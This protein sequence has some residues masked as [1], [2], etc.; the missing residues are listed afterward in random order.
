MGLTAAFQ[1]LDLSGPKAPPA[2][3]GKAILAEAEALRAASG[4]LGTATAAL[5]GLAAAM[6]AAGEAAG[7]SGSPS[8]ILGLKIAH[9]LAAVERMLA[10][11]PPPVVEQLRIE[12]ARLAASPPETFIEAL[13]LRDLL[14]PLVDATA[15]DHDAAA[16]VDVPWA[17][18]N[19]SLGTMT[20]DERTRIAALRTRLEQAS[21]SPA[22]RRVA[23]IWSVQYADVLGMASNPPA[24]L[25]GPA[26]S[27]WA[28]ST[29]AVFLSLADHPNSAKAGDELARL[30]SIA[31]VARA[32]ESPASPGEAGIAP[33]SGAARAQQALNKAITALP[34]VADHARERTRFA[35]LARAAGLLPVRRSLA[36]SAD[37]VRQLKPAMRTLNELAKISENELAETFPDAF[38]HPDAATL[39]K[40]VAAMA[41]HRRRLDDLRLL[42]ELDAKLGGQLDG[43]ASRTVSKEFVP[44]AERALSFSKDVLELARKDDPQ[45]RLELFDAMDRWRHLAARASDVAHM[46]GESELRRDGSSLASLL[47]DQRDS[48]I[49]AIDADRASWIK[50]WAAPDRQPLQT[51]SDRLERVR[52]SLAMAQDAAAVLSS[53]PLLANSLACWEI[54]HG[55]RMAAIKDLE[56]TI[57][58]LT[59]SAIDGGPVGLVGQTPSVLAS[60]GLALVMGR[61]ERLKSAERHA[62][63]GAWSAIEE[64]TAGPTP[65]EPPLADRAS[66][67]ML[68][69]R[70]APEWARSDSAGR[71]A[72]MEYLG[73]AI[74]RC[75]AEIELEPQQP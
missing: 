19:V 67:L 12:A 15:P 60:H 71:R 62:P 16:G 28:A 23:A 74:A 46:P 11:A 32:L 42:R 8:A 56:R 43:Q 31:R 33:G 65:G 69:A 38:A 2:G 48:L 29:K 10:S 45:S 4:K 36:G 53:Q 41:Q 51:V 3:E 37:L 34:A 30:V 25:T 49:K 18:A 21:A 55:T 22:Y 59:E 63:T 26:R 39:P 66:D 52:Q 47:A 24:F 17:A 58:S 6:L 27:A 75:L 9:R 68:I 64:L 40:L 20:A 73:P 54:S 14:A 13:A 61:L 1:P 44:V 57:Q 7:P 5:S 35:S 50:A 70:Y 72:I